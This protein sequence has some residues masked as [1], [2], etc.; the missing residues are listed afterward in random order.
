M[1]EKKTYQRTSK[2]GVS[3]TLSNLQ[4]KVEKAKGR[5]P[6]KKDPYAAA[7]LTADFGGVVGLAKIVGISGSYISMAIF[8]VLMSLSLLVFYLHSKGR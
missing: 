2:K 3:G 7:V 6:R 5:S 4:S 8:V 1:A